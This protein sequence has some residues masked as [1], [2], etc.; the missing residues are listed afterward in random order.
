MKGE[1]ITFKCLGL[2][3]GRWREWGSVK[4]FMFGFEKGFEESC[5]A[6]SSSRHKGRWVRQQI[7]KK[8]KT[9]ALSVLNKERVPRQK[10]LGGRNME[11]EKVMHPG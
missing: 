2:V 1:R 4:R 3:A 5:P 7:K 6:G 9:K 11:A 10:D 8:E